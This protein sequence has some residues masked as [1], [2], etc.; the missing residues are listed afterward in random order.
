MKTVG[1]IGRM[2][3]ETTAQF[4]LEVVFGCAKLGGEQRPAILTWNVPLPYR[5]EEALLTRGAQVDEYLPF[6]ITAAGIL[7]KGGAD[8]LVMPCNTLHRYLDEIRESVSIPMISIAEVV[9]DHLHEQKVKSIG[10]IATS[11]TLESGFYQDA[12][13]EID[14][15]CHTPDEF[16][17]AKLA[18]M[19]FNLVTNRYANQQ[20]Q[21]LLEVISDLE[22]QG[23]RTILLACTDLQALIPHSAHLQIIDTMQILADSTVKE[24]CEVTT[25]AVQ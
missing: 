1:V 17:Q 3:P 10:L 13:S 19:I 14:I 4:Y 12:L 15:S 2:G 24:I 9:R 21:E 23:V 16:Q 6:L 22:E 20:R 11:I 5:V 25:R 7:E 18:N 8:F